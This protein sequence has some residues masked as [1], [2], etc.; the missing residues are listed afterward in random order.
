M[1]KQTLTSTWLEKKTEHTHEYPPGDGV[2]SI[3]G[4][5]VSLRCALDRR[6]PTPDPVQVYNEEEDEYTKTCV[7]CGFQYSYEKM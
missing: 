2:R 3:D 5:C 1:R 4:G 6:Q 7:T